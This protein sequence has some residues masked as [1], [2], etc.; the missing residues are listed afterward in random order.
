MPSSFPVPEAIV[1]LDRTVRTVP[2]LLETRAAEI[3]GSTAVVAGPDRRTY[4]DLARSASRMA[5]A[6]RDAGVTPGNVVVVVSTNRVEMLDVMF[7][8]AWLGAVTVPIDPQSRGG[9]LTS[10]LEQTA[11]QFLFA[12]TG[13][14]DRL[15]EA[16]FRGRLWEFG[17]PDTPSP[18]TGRPVR[19]IAAGPLDTAMILFTSG[20]TGRPKGV[21]C[22][23]AQFLHWGLGVGEALELTRSDV[24]F[25]CLP[26]FHTN[27]I[28]TVFQALVAGCTVALGSRF[29]VSGHW[30]EATENGATVTYLLGAMVAMLARS[31]TVPGERTHRVTRSL[32]PATPAHLYGPFRDRFGVRLVDGFGSTETNLVVGTTVS[33]ARP[34]YIGTVRPGYEATVADAEDGEPGELIVR[35]LEPG[36]F[37]TG[38]LGEPTPAPDAWRRTG[39]R[40]VRE[41]DGWFRFV[42]RIKDVIRR[43][44]EN[45]S[46]LEV[47]WA[48]S[49][50]PAVAQVAVFAVP[51]D[52]A[53]DDIM[54]AVTLRRGVSVD[55]AALLRSGEEHLPYFAIPRYLDVVDAL[56]LTETGKVRKAELAARGVRSRTWDAE[57]HGYRPERVPRQRPHPLKEHTVG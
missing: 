17:Q 10:V 56:P 18:S 29:S 43:R 25:T 22:P 9:G 8:C 26:L 38:Y 33:A 16:G 42:D 20:T 54:A 23:H 28:N 6:L 57:A 21:R 36:A 41:P 12:E 24:L 32:A 49:R 55:P 34:G 39:D 46:S 35:A 52:L 31:D 3:G 5:G 4:S 15:R 30:A 1:V 14:R 48:L 19:A 37:A 2:D 50:H 27:A 11:A 51:S 13:H 40:V 53:E 44:G 45:V 7:G 47:E